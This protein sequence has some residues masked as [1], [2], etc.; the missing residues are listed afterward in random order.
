MNPV[1]LPPAVMTKDEGGV[2]AKL[3]KLG[4]VRLNA[5]PVSPEIP[6]S[7]RL[8]A[9]PAGGMRK[10]PPAFAIAGHEV[11]SMVFAPLASVRLWTTAGLK[12]LNK[13]K[14]TAWPLPAMLKTAPSVVVLV[15]TPPLPVP[16][17]R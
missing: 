9:F 17:V 16:M 3:I 14:S 2:T 13:L 15:P 1:T 4:A 12:A 7:V 11:A 5:M 8:C 10:H 6:L